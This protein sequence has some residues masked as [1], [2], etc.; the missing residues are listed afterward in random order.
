[1]NLVIVESPFAGDVAKHIRY[2]RAALA[3]CLRRGEAPFASHLLYT[4][5]GVLD[6]GVLGDRVLGI[7]AGLQWGRVSAGTV[8]YTDCGIS[9]GMKMG[10]TRALLEGRHV[11]YRQIPSW[12]G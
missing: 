4:Q 12:V 11:E 6:D 10:I 5:E 7:E 1:M 9:E 3:D 2:A 8:V